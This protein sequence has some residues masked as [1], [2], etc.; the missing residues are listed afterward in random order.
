MSLPPNL[1]VPE[2]DGACDHLYTHPAVPSV[3]LQATDQSVVSLSELPGMTIVFLYPRTA[4]AHENIPESWN[5]IPGAR[6][7][8]PQACSFRD[9]LPSLK[10]LG[11]TQVFG[12]STQSTDYQKEAH[13]RLHL[14]YSL[15]SNDKL[16]FIQALRLPTFEWEGR[17]LSKRITLAIEG[18]KVVHHWY[19][20]F[21]PDR[22]VD[23]VLHW[24]KSRQSV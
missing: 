17:T 11:V 2:D 22:N 3:A 12:L 5:S 6:G 13:D 24:L 18:G 4:T 8:S 9:N 19:P 15:L 14:A 16:E 7:C 10:Q 1:P 21:P 23:D 20:V